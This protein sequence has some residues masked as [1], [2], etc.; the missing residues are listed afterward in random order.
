M[1]NFTIRV[2]EDKDVS[3][4]K[5]YSKETGWRSISESERK[6]LDKEQ[7]SKRMEE[8]FDKFIKK[9]TRKI[10]VAE[11]ENG[12]FLGYIFVGEGSSMMSGVTHGFIYDIFVKEEFRGRGIGTK[13]IEKAESYCRQRGYSRIMLMVSPNNQSAVGL[14]AKIGFKAIHVYMEKTLSQRCE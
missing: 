13:L 14:Y 6:A 1:M 9:E 2:A 3:L 11:G 10:F 4:I 5:E 8:V 7:W 12:G